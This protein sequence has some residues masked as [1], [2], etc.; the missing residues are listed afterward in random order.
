M[1]A[2]GAWCL[3]EQDVPLAVLLSRSPG[4]AGSRRLHVVMMPLTVRYIDC[5]WC[6][7][8]RRV[9]WHEV[10]PAK[11]ETRIICGSDSSVVGR[12]CHQKGNKL[13]RGACRKRR[14]P[15]GAHLGIDSTEGLIVEL[16]VGCLGPDINGMFENREISARRCGQASKP[17]S[18]S[19]RGTHFPSIILRLSVARRSLTNRIRIFFDLVAMAVWSSF[20]CGQ[21]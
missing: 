1:G 5:P 11:A 21:P 6:S 17:D 10:R 8:L 7:R 3:I 14:W 19:H 12:Q 4:T 20:K 16:L 9:W 13:Q 2:P 18:G 15:P